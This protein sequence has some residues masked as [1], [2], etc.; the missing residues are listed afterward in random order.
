LKA[1]RFNHN[2]Q[3]YQYRQNRGFVDTIG[4]LRKRAFA[5]LGEV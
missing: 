4:G 3:L 2:R 1:I 5:R